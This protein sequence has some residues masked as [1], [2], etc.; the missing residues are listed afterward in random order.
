[1]TKA[2]CASARAA[3]MILRSFA[4]MAAGS[5]SGFLHKYRF[6][7]VEARAAT[8]EPAHAALL[9]GAPSPY[10]L[11]EVSGRPIFRLRAR[12]VKKNEQIPCVFGKL[13]RSVLPFTTGDRYFDLCFFHRAAAIFLPIALSFFSPSFFARAGPPFNPP[14][15]PSATAAGSLPASAGGGAGSSGVSPVA[16]MTCCNTPKAKDAGSGVFGLRFFLAMLTLCGRSGRIARAVT[17]R[18]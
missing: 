11:G 4:F 12:R 14:L 17:H 15:R 8:R 13:S 3:A 18:H 9:A 1:M 5:F 6:A 7:I 16:P 10:R 2:A